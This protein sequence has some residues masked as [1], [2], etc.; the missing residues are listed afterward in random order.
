MTGV[1]YEPAFGSLGWD[2][3]RSRRLRRFIPH[4]AFSCFIANK[5]TYANR[6]LGHAWATQGPPNPRPK[7][8]RRGVVS[9][10]RC[11]LWL[12]AS[13]YLLA[14]LFSKTVGTMAPCSRIIS[15][16]VRFCQEKN[17]V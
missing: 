11:Q 7:P 12:I 13:C 5:G 16:F 3:V 6:R 17:M 10:C 8:S 9:L 1:P 4:P 2:D 15:Y 14:A